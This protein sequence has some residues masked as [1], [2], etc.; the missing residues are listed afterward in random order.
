MRIFEI[1]AAGGF[2]LSQNNAELASLFAIGR[3]CDCFNSA[4]EAAEKIAYYL[5]GCFKRPV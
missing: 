5:R 1:T 4:M 3:E 2:L